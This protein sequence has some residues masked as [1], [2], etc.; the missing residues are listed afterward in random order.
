MGTSTPGAWPPR[1]SS[2]DD[3]APP[4]VPGRVRAAGLAVGLLAIGGV[5]VWA[6]TDPGGYGPSADG[7][8]TVTFASST[9]GTVQ[10]ECGAVA[11]T[12]CDSAYTRGDSLALLIRKEC[13]PAGLAPAPASPPPGR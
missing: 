9:G 4:R 2:P 6:A 13:G 5:A 3:A 7:C 1:T 12:W 11:R 8:V 10:H